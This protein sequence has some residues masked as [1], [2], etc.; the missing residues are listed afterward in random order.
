MNPEAADAIKIAD[1]HLGRGSPE[2]RAAL[3]K[4]IVDAIIRHAGV[5]ASEA[6][7]KA[8]ASTGSQKH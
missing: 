2:R 6:I 1:K 7:S 3:A 5:I 4:D 8:F